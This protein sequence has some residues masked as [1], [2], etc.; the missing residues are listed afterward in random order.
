MRDIMEQYQQPFFEIVDSPAKSDF[1]AMPYEFLDVFDHYPNY[2]NQAYEKARMTQ[3][4]G[5]AF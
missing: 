4:K 5:S 1:F 3:K 2:L